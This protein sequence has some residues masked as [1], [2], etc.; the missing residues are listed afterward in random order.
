[1]KPRKLDRFERMVLK[2]MEEDGCIWSSGAVDL[3]RK[4]HAWMRRTV[5][6]L[7]KATSGNTWVLRGSRIAYAIMLSKL[8][9][10]RK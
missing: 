6:E 2:R 1:M 9:Q 4:E 8:E 10:R 3:I 7:F 5:K